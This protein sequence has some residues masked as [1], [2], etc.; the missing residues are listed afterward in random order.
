MNGYRFTDHLGEYPACES[1]LF[2][3]GAEAYGKGR[4]L[5]HRGACFDSSRSEET[6][7]YFVKSMRDRYSL[8]SIE[9]HRG[10]VFYYPGI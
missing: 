8:C 1:F 3:S 7:R 5:P 10:P 6:G 4:N 9:E 2:E